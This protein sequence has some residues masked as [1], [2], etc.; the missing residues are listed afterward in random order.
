MLGRTRDAAS[1]VAGRDVD[2]LL[3]AEGAFEHGT[4]LR[5]MAWE[6][7]KYSHLEIAVAPSLTDVAA[8]RVEI[9]PVAG[10]PLVYVGHTRAQDSAHWAKRVFD[11]VGSLGAPRAVV[12]ASGS[13]P[14][15]ASSSTT[16]GRCSSA[17]PG[18]ASRARPSSA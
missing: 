9:R 5:Q 16:A 15:C 12:A 1:I 17:R 18:S 3:F 10:L 13:G 4:T 2:T 6:L 11:I 14:R 7:E 8:G